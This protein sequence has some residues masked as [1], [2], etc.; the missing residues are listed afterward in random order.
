MFS[1]PQKGITLGEVAEGD[2]LF[3]TEVDLH[4]NAL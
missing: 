2:L 4:K 1:R 3:S